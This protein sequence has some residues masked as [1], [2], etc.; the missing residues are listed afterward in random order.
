MTACSTGVADLWYVQ[1]VVNSAILAQLSLLTKKKYY[2][3]LQFPEFSVAKPS[4][5]ICHEPFSHL[6]PLL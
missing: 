5:L 4:P 1:D 6:P 3:E 2:S